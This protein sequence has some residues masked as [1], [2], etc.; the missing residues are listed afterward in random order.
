M[1][2][3]YLRIKAEHPDKLL[4][5]RMGDFYE[6]FYDDARARGAA[7]RHHADRARPVGGRADPDGRRA[8]ITRSSS[9]SRSWCGSGESVAICE[10][11]GDPATSKGP[12]ERKVTRI[13]TP[14]TLTDAGLLDEQARLPA[15]RAASR[16]RRA[17][18][19]AWLNLAGGRLHAARRAA[20]RGRQRCS[21]ASTPARSC[22][23]T[24]ARRSPSRGAPAH[25]LPPWQ[26]DARRRRARALRRN[27]AR[28]ILP[29]SAPRTRRSRSPPPA[30]C[31]TTRR[32]RSR[33]RSRTCARSPSSARPTIWRS[34]PR[35]GAT[36]RSPRRCAARPAPTLFR[37]STAAH[38]RRQPPAAPLAH[39]S[40][41]RAVR[42]GVARHDGDRGAGAA[43]ADRAARCA[44]RCKT[45][46]DVERIAARI[47]LRQRAA[48][49]SRRPAR[50]A[51]A[52]AGAGDVARRLRSRALLAARRGSARGRIALGGAPRPRDRRRARGRGA[53]RRRDRGRLRRRAGRAARD[54]GQLRRVPGRAR[55][56][57][58]RSAPASPT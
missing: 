43:R 54:P 1:M 45:T 17:A 22:T 18:G 15:G 26:F 14:G 2:Q 19:I 13:V 53:R 24:T 39:Q 11:I 23:P 6:L 21:S 48:A 27:S 9:I 31:S 5:Y 29:R 52:P 50:H 32:R 40:A 55:G 44:R 46:V 41:A 56:A 20:G 7:A 4:F 37:C 42:R 38:R 35:R 58:A 12:V 34:T 28:A 49:R 30:R 36:S 33:R 57:R 51:A 8:R 16:R 3:Q 10:Q 25:A 47:A